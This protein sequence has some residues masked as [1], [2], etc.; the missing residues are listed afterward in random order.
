MQEIAKSNTWA[1]TI[2]SLG[3]SV[4]SDPG[5]SRPLL[6]LPREE[7]EQSSDSEYLE[8]EKRI[9]DPGE[10]PPIYAK[11][12]GSIMASSSRPGFTDTTGRP[13]LANYPGFDVTGLGMGQGNQVD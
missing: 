2:V 8:V 12:L 7:N 6:W 3:E 1:S 11:Q 13:T 4:A 5:S 10:T 9:I